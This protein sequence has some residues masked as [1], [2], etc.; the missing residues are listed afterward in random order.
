VFKSFIPLS[1][2]FHAY[3]YYASH[4]PPSQGGI[5]VERYVSDSSVRH[6]GFSKDQTCLETEG[7]MGAYMIY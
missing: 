2:A 3:E 5:R 1:P 7:R 6:T 4:L